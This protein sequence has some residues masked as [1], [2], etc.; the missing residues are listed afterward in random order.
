MKLSP[1]LADNLWILGG[2]LGFAESYLQ[3]E[4]TT[5]DLTAV[6]RFFGGNLPQAR[7]A[8]QETRPLRWAR[9]RPMWA[10]EEFQC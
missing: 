10:D 1:I 5:D 3:A 6:L 4:W 8:E 2:A 9:C 7:R